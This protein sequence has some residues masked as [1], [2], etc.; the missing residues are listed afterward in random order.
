MSKRRPGQFSPEAL[1]SGSPLTSTHVLVDFQSRG[2][3][4]I[5][6]N[7]KR[8]VGCER[9][10]CEPTLGNEQDFSEERHCE[11]KSSLSKLSGKN[12]FQALPE[13]VQ[14]LGKLGIECRRLQSSNFSQA[15]LHTSSGADKDAKVREA[16]KKFTPVL[17]RDSG[18]RLK[19]RVT[20]KQA[21]SKWAD[22]LNDCNINSQ[23][24]ASVYAFNAVPHI[25]LP[26][27][28]M[29]KSLKKL[30][31]E[32][33]EKRHDAVSSADTCSTHDEE[34]I[35]EKGFQ[36]PKLDL[37]GLRMR[38]SS[39]FSETATLSSSPSS[40]MGDSPTSASS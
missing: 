26:H 13:F 37:R 1:A 25:K 30:L 24:L 9:R 5:D 4:D 17:D 40:L 12:Q 33:S 6:R 22:E 10:A 14:D 21:R 7:L 15:G 27:D 8:G 11:L 3:C 34:L 19:Q 38:E 20:S 29:S 39:D 31:T 35:N 2:I 28:A 32:A 23:R 16:S 36:I 18:S